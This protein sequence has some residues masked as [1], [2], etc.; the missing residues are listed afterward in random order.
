M[1]TPARMR[2]GNQQQQHLKPAQQDLQERSPLYAFTLFYMRGILVTFSHLLLQRRQKEKNEM[3]ILNCAIKSCL[4]NW[5]T[6]SH[7]PYLQQALQS[8]LKEKMKTVNGAQTATNKKTLKLLAFNTSSISEYRP[9]LFL[10]AIN[11]LLR[12]RAKNWPPYAS[13]AERAVVVLEKPARLFQL[14]CWPPEGSTCCQALQH[15]T[16]STCTRTIQL[17]SD[18]GAAF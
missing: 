17:S 5:R 12:P 6:A 3:H 15:K 2:L 13:E 16:N 8:L 4:L 11:T 14:P 7:T 10:K 18:T 9:I 1:E